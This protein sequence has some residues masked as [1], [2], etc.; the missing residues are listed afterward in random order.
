MNVVR[1][2]DR[3]DLALTKTTR[4]RHVEKLRN[5][6]SI[7]VLRFKHTASP[8]RTG[9][10]QCCTHVL[11][12]K[13]NHAPQ[14]RIGTTAIPHMKPK[15]LPHTRL[16]R[17]RQSATPSL[18]T[19]QTAHQEITHVV[20]GPI[21]VDHDPGHQAYAGKMQVFGIER[22]QDG[23]ELLDGWLTCQ[24]Q[25]DIVLRRRHHE[26]ATDWTRPLRD[27]RGHAGHIDLN[28]NRALRQDALC[29]NQARSTGRRA[30]SK[31]PHEVDSAYVCCAQKA[32]GWRSERIRKDHDHTLSIWQVVGIFQLDHFD[33]VR[34]QYTRPET[35]RCLLLGLLTDANHATGNHGTSDRRLGK[36]INHGAAHRVCLVTKGIRGQHDDQCWRGPGKRHFDLI[37]RAIDGRLGVGIV[38]EM[39]GVT[40]H[41]TEVLPVADSCVAS[42]HYAATS[43]SN[44]RP[45]V[46]TRANMETSMGTIV[47]ELYADDAP[48]T[49]ENFTKLAGEG[50]YDGLIFHRV[51]PD[52]M[53]Q[54]GCPDG[55][56]TGGPG[57]KFEDEQN[58]HDVD[59]GKLAMANAGPNTN[60]SQF[61][62]VT[63]PDCNW[64]KGKH[65]VFGNVIEGLDIADAISAVDRDG[66]DM[67]SEP[68]TMTVTIVED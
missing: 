44:E 48:K 20:V 39:R 67:P 36:A 4:Q 26:V 25:H 6:G 53:I 38:G 54:G 11:V 23:V 55:T 29:G 50:F 41:V 43:T 35:N 17:N 22:A 64:L 45:A 46:A 57:Y 40:N 28:T 32:I 49:V 61:F 19:E 66:R 5:H 42:P 16:C 62:I 33:L 10:D 63:A 9:K 59:R 14:V 3:A 37:G 52:F 13:T 24:L 51:I 47:I 21:L 15:R 7:V 31:A 2:R 56:G 58:S 27:D 65:T 68:I 8:A 12:G 18:N 30:T 34:R 1:A 60:G